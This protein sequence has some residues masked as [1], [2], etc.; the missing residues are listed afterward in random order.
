MFVANEFRATPLSTFDADITERKRR[1]ALRMDAYLQRRSA[2]HGPRSHYPHAFFAPK[3]GHNRTSNTRP[4]AETARPRFDPR[5]MLK[6][7]GYE[8]RIANDS[9]TLKRTT[10]RLIERMY[11]SRGLFPYAQGESLDERNI[12]ISACKGNEQAVATLTLCID[13]GEG[14]LADTL[15]RE[16]IDTARKSGGRVCEITRL[17]MDP[18]HSSHEMLAGM[19][20][21]LYVLTRLTF[22]VTDLYIEVHPRHAGFYRRL[23]GYRTAGPEKICPRVGAPAILMHL[24]QHQLDT[25]IDTHAGRTDNDSRCLYRLFPQRAELERIQQSLLLEPSQNQRLTSI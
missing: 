24:C 14:L 10:A 8:I 3:R 9:P 11:A 16:E 25:L 5:F 20:Q 6:C 21:I 4:H 2:D 19:M 1:I 18:E 12:T 15:Y 7:E 13:A 22:R 23:L 17:A